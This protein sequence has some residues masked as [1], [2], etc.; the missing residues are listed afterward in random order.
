MDARR[1]R[2]WRH[3]QHPGLQ[4]FV[5]CGAHDLGALAGLSQQLPGQDEKRRL[6]AGQDSVLPPRRGSRVISDKMAISSDTLGTDRTFCRSISTVS[7]PFVPNMRCWR[8][9]PQGVAVPVSDVPRRQHGGRGLQDAQRLFALSKEATIESV[10]DYD[11]GV[12]DFMLTVVVPKMA[13]LLD[14]E[15][16]L[17]LAQGLA[18]AR[19]RAPSTRTRLESA[20]L[21]SQAAS[22]QLQ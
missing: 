22:H 21:S 16:A 3:A 6:P 17:D 2:V 11:A 5:S 14:Q 10:R 20:F 9:P 8:V 15:S 1:R 12:T 18:V 13:E 7:Y 4:R 19:V